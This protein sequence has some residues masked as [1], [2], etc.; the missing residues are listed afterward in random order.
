MIA[1]PDTRTDMPGAS[2]NWTPY[3]GASKISESEFYQI[4][5]NESDA[6]N[7]TAT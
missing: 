3:Y 4:S 1:E 7:T 5:D 6:M 2:K